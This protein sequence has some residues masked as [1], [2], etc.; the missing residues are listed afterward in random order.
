MRIKQKIIYSKDVYTKQFLTF[1][2]KYYLSGYGQ[3][4]KQ[5]FQMIKYSILEYEK[6]K[7][8]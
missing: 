5:A 7:N 3:S 8:N 4:R 6:F 2:P 1:C